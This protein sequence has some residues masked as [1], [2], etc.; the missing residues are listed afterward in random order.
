VHIPS[1]SIKLYLVVY[2]RL[3]VKLILVS[4]F[5]NKDDEI[6]SITN[7]EQGFL[8]KISKN[9]RRCE[10]QKEALTGESLKFSTLRYHLHWQY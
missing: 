3:E 4:Y 7:P 10:V 5:V 9:D 2:G 8:Y 6:R 1:R